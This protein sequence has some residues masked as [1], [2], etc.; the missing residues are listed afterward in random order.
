LILFIP[1]CCCE[2]LFVQ[3]LLFV[4]YLICIQYSNL[5]TMLPFFIY[6]LSVISLSVHTHMSYTHYTSTHKSQ[7]LLVE[8]VQFLLS[9]IHAY[10]V[11]TYRIHSHTGQSVGSGVL[12]RVVFWWPGAERT[13]ILF[14]PGPH[15]ICFIVC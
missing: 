6:Y 2:F 10:T 7:V 5:I 3:L 12:S 1:V 9:A 13:K 11:H 15:K 8:P 4:H 14:V